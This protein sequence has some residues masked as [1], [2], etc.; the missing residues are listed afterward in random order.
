MASSTTTCVFYVPFGGPQ[1]ETD[2]NKLAMFLY[3]AWDTMAMVRRR[4]V[5]FRNVCGRNTRT[6]AGQLPLSRQL[7]D[8][9]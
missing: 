4:G 5:C 7:P 8:R 9:R 3:F 1:D 6:R 2:V